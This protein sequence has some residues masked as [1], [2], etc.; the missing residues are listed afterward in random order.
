MKNRSLM[1]L[2][3]AFMAYSADAVDF[4][5]EWLNMQKKY[6]SILEKFSDTRV[7]L[8]EKYVLKDWEKFQVALG[9]LINGS[10]N[11]NFLK[12]NF[13]LQT[14]LRQGITRVQ[15]YELNYM[16]LFLNASNK[17]LV[18]SYKDTNFGG[19]P[20]DFRQRNCNVNTLGQLFYFS[21]VIEHYKYDTINTIVEFG[22]GYGCLCRIAKTLLPNATY[23]IIDLP[24]FIALQSF[25][26][27]MTLDGARIKVH[28]EVPHDLDSGYIHLIPVY[29]LDELELK[30]DV[31]ISTFALSECPIYTHKSVV[32]KRFFDADLCYIT[33]QI[34]GWNPI[35]VEGPFKT[36]AAIVEG[37][38]MLYKTSYF[39]P[40]HEDYDFKISSYEL[41][42]FK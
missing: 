7:A 42:G 36:E 14:M 41:M 1:L 21:K 35:G 39:Y 34:N 16:N 6:H 5:S 33:G 29:L 18:D 3:V 8:Q 17:K 23:V 22:G 32:K 30:T 38:R 12:H 40:F 27:T 19:I 2:M 20:F 28:L 26:L 37:I 13:F 25:Y 10:P 15:Q 9:N 31:F 4:G 11:V 24:E